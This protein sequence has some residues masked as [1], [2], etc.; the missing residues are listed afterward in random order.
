[1]LECCSILDSDISPKFSANELDNAQHLP[2]QGSYQSTYEAYLAEVAHFYNNQQYSLR[3]LSEISSHSAFP[4]L[5][6]RL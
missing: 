2:D 6:I 1:M 5:R 3:R 4:S